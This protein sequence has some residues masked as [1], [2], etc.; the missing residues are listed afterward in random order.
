MKHL[1]VPVSDEFDETI[2]RRMVEGGFGSMAEYLRH[3]VRQDLERADEAKLER[4]L[5]DGFE[6]GEPVEMTDEWI[7]ERRRVLTDRISDRRGKKR[8]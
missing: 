4:L 7:Q 2:R 6:S 8:A 3:T 1:S 5:L